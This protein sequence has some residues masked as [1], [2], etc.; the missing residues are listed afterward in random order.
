MGLKTGVGDQGKQ[1]DARRSTLDMSS[2]K[3]QA[4]S[5]F[6]SGHTACAGCPMPVI[7]RHVLDVLGKDTIVVNATSC[8]EIISSQYPTSAFKTPYIHSLFE[9]TPAVATGVVRALR[10]MGNNHT[11]VVIIAGDG[12]T[13]D[14]GFGAMS[15]AMERNEDIIYIC[16]DNEAYMNCLT[17]DALIMTE[18]GLRNIT[19]VKKGDKLYAFDPNTHELVLKECAG[20]YDNGT[21]RVFSVETLHHSVKATGNHPFLVIKHTG[22]GKENEFVWK[23]VEELKNGDELI[24]LKNLGE[25]KSFVFPIVAQ[26]TKT[27]Y[28]VN[29]LNDITIPKKSSLSL[30]EYLGIYLGDGWVRK[31]RGVVGFALPKLKERNRMLQLHKEVFKSKITENKNEVNINSVNLATFIN[32]LGF[33]SGAKTKTIPDWVYLLPLEEKE[34]FVKGLLLSDGYEVKN[35]NSKRYVSASFE[36]LKRL[37]LLLQTM[38]YRVGKIHSQE[39]KAG[40]QVVKRKL[41]KDSTYGYICFSKLTNWNLQKYASQYKY[42]N[43]LVDNSYFNVEK[44]TK[45]TDLGMEPTLDLQVTG[46]HNFIANGYVVHNTGVQRSSATPPLAKTTTSPVGSKIHGKMMPKKPIVEICAAHG[47]PY[48]ASA[49]IAYLPDFKAKLEKAKA[50]K[51]FRF[52]DVISPCVP[53][54]GYDP[55]ISIELSRLA[56]ETGMWELFEIEKGVRKDTFKPGQLKPVE[57]YLKPQKRFKH[58]TT[59]EIAGIQK[60][61]LERTKIPL[62]K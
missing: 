2:L 48:S 14:I 15:G 27:D 59:E 37:R 8:S 21:K 12:S 31:N 3:P 17:K 47:I 49:S 50:M 11:Q 43:F 5:L 55:A 38:G 57:L 29:N 62:L 30:M 25:G 60:G 6:A 44:V 16:Y 20:V 45:I 54:W 18:T 7:I 4:S 53:G 52:I 26:K 40:T 41:L 28:K 10:A 1:L 23:K 32:S 34:A 22:R 33:G 35:S 9:N 36:L 61:I 51:G 13:Y 19:E 46:V 24:V 58:L 42:Q 56:V 39:K